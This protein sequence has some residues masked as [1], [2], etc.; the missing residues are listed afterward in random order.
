MRILMWAL[1]VKSC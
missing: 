1:A